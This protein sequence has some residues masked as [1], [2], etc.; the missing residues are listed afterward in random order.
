MS[1]STPANG[2]LRLPNKVVE[3]LARIRITGTQYALIFAICRRTLCWQQTGEWK[4]TPYPISSTELA[5]ATHQ[6]RR[7]LR[8]DLHDLERRNIITRGGDPK[9]VNSA[10][11]SFN[12]DCD[13]WAGV[14]PAPTSLEGLRVKEPK[15]KRKFSEG[16]LTPSREVREEVERV[17]EGELPPSENGGPKVSEGELTP[18][19]DGSPASKELVRGNSPPLSEGELTPSLRGNSPPVADTKSYLGKKPK[20][21]NKETVASSSAKK[22]ATLG[23]ETP[24]SE[25]FF[26]KTGRKRW[27][28]QLQKEL[29][30][31]AEADLGVEAMTRAINWALLK[32]ITNIQSII[33]AAR[34]GKHGRDEGGTRLPERGT[35]PL[36]EARAEGWTIVGDGGES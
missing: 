34:G 2:H 28:N 4:N 9:G 12:L 26:S 6:D 30:E 13:K 7:Q 15:R 22:K 36:E 20:E 1:E 14:K 8:R 25:Y 29:F 3:A 5:E 33:T 19:K 18:T 21:T 24:T 11:M 31:S 16:E 35:D 27:Q 17:S 10:L 32:G 23:P